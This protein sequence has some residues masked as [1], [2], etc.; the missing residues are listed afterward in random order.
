M[1]IQTTLSSPLSLS[2]PLPRTMGLN[3]LALPLKPRH[4]AGHTLTHHWTWQCL[5]GT[6]CQTKSLSPQKFDALGLT[7]LKPCLSPCLDEA[8]H[9]SKTCS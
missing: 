4:N 6:A 9:R 5:G 3:G 1:H 2:L 8:E 7:R